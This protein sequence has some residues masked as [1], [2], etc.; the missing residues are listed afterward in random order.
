MTA[1]PLITG[2]KFGS[3]SPVA[4]TRARRCTLIFAPPVV[5][6]HHKIRQPFD[7]T[8][9]AFTA[10]FIFGLKSPSTVPID[11]LGAVPQVNHVNTR[12]SLARPFLVVPLIV[13]NGPPR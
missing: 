13:V 1:H 12:P 3:I 8:P 5:N 10:L 2:I 6:A 9:S 4:L 7:C 11:A